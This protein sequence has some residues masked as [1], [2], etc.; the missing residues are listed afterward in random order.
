LPFA[1]AGV[2]IQQRSNLRTE[3]F[4]RPKEA[5]ERNPNPTRISDSNPDPALVEIVKGWPQSINDE[6]A[7]R[8]W[9]GKPDFTLAEAVEDFVQEMRGHAGY[10]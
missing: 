2:A 9:Q 5:R 8:D 10:P 7:T 3:L 6:E 4:E 1:L